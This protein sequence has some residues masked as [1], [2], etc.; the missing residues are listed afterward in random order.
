MRGRDDDARPRRERD[1]APQDAPR[2]AQDAPAAHRG[3]PAPVL[4]LA[5]EAKAIGSHLRAWYTTTPNRREAI[6]GG[7]LAVG[8][9]CVAGRLLYLQ[10]FMSGDLSSK[11]YT[12]RTANIA[13][14]HRRG[15]IYD[16]YGNVLA[17]STDAFDIAIHPYL[18]V[19]A[20]YENAMANTLSEVL[21]GSAQ[22]YWDMITKAPTEADIEAGNVDPQT[23][24][25]LFV[26][27]KRKASLRQV[28][29]LKAALKEKKLSGLEYYETFARKYPEGSLAGN[30]V[31]LFGDEDENGVGHGLTGL[32]LQYD[33]VLGGVD[34]WVVEERSRFGSPIVGGL[35][36]RVEPEDG[37]SIVI[38]IDLDIQKI[39]QQ[40]LE[41][42][43]K[44]WK[45]Q[46]GVVVVTN[47]KT[48]EIYACASLP[49]ADISD[50]ST[51][52]N[53]SLVNKAVSYNFEPGSTFK[54][55]TVAAAVELGLADSQTKYYC[56]AQIQ[57]GDDM[58]G[59]SDKRDYDLEM[60]L[61][62]IL[63]RSSNVGTVLVADSMGYDNFVDYARR[64]KIGCGS[65]VDYPGEQPS[66]TAGL[67]SYIG[68][69][70]AMAFGQA[71]SVS[72]MQMIRAV[73]ALANDGVI[74]QP[75]FLL[76][77]G[78]AEVSYPA[79]ERVVS[80]RTAR[81]VTQMMQSV[82]ENG[83]GRTGQVEGYRLA[84][85]TGTSERYDERTGGYMEDAVT[86]SFIGYGPTDNPQV[87]VYVLIDNVVGGQGSTVAGPPWGVIMKAA[88]E[89]LQIAPSY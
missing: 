62:E 65:E 20:A 59:D 3:L 11:A 23:N 22:Y 58:V 28:E 63:E 80:T 26:Y 6:V 37:E 9:A 36:E 12:E 61:V 55:L 57:V 86:V 84:G 50:T 56:P 7:F 15:A 17:N 81:Q 24:R 27:V 40:Q 1:R 25:R 67:D 14:R 21:G 16:R 69:W 52:T 34:G 8:F 38:S 41:Q 88:L 19:T 89:K 71:I 46:T 87:L 49:Y 75:H 73:G 76:K 44:D 47:P 4:R 13:L 70:E 42:T 45:A 10:T 32:E 66:G 33:S 74:V 82:V 60:T 51:I 68:N 53:E 78:G 5:D 29:D 54:P 83:Y 77:R 43:V 35:K 2:A 30:I 39:A 31:G 64:F 48:G 18:V 85:K 72:P 79:G